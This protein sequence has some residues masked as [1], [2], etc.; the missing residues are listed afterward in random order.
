MTKQKK[1]R[2]K[3]YTGVD[4][5]IKQPVITKISAANRSK[6]GQWWFDNKRIAKPFLKICGVVAFIIIVII[7]II[8]IAH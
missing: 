5:A 7:E 6:L 1:K 8:Q 4:A 2:N 3:P